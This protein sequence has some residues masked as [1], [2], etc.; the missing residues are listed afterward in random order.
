MPKQVVESI[1]D[2]FLRRQERTISG[3]VRMA[4]NATVGESLT[5]GTF[6]STEASGANTSMQ[7]SNTAISEFRPTVTKQ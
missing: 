2:F 1:E 4:A 6:L 7:V 3:K 5:S